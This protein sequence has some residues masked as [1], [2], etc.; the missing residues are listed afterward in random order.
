[1]VATETRKWWALIAIAASVVVVGLDLTVL[2]LALPTLARDLHASTGDLQWFSDAY[3]LVLAAAVLPAGLLGDRI[4]RKKVLLY[5]L[6]AFGASSAACAYAGGVGELIAARAVLGLGAA[7]I[8]PLSLSVLPVLF[9]AEE[10]PKAIAIMASA[11][12]LS[13]P[14]GPLLGGWLLDNFWWGSV[15]LINVPVVALALI[16]VA[17]L[18]PESRSQQRP[19]MDFTGVLISALGLTG[20]TYGFIKAGQNGWSDAASLATI[21]AGVV[22]LVAFVGWE[23]RVRARRGQPVVDLSLFSSA[24]FTWGTLLATL[25]S[26]SLFGVL[27]AMPLY[28]QDVRGLS[29]LGSGLRLLPLIGGMVA[30]MIGGSRLQNP[31]RR[32]DGQPAAPPV[33]LKVLVTVGYVVMAAGLAVGT[34]TRAGSGTGFASAW[35]AVAGLGLGIAMPAAM[36]AAISALSAERSGSGTAL[37]TAMR[38]VGATIGVAVLGTV[39]NDAYRS[40][41]HLAGL[42]AA[43]ASAVRQG[44]SAGVQVAHEAGSAV[45]LDLVRSSYVHGLDVM[46]WVCAGIALVSAL[47]A[48]LFLPRVAG[49]ARPPEAGEAGAASPADEAQRAELGR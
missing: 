10:R 23:R 7:A 3:S 47:L 28:F 41:L 14:I 36:N 1:M 17:F 20:V 42:P 35:F 11:T 32:T 21:A 45:L 43:A 46:L 26:F 33:S 27:F 44:V 39:I 6:A 40:G 5:A 4:G 38:Q 31:R 8:L 49:E 19:R 30:G 48:L 24:G 16:A 13:F 25:V 18:M 34:L 22:V 15:F 9:T 37:I 2:N 12:F 29:A